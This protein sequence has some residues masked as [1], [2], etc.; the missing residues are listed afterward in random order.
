MNFQIFHATCHAEAAASTNNLV[1]RLK[2]EMATGSRG[3]TPEVMASRSTPPPVRVI[4]SKSPSRSPSS[5]QSKLAGTKRKVDFDGLPESLEA[6]CTPPSKKL[7]L[8]QS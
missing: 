6:D 2:N 1:A 8:A 5:T 3:S 7:A 4:K